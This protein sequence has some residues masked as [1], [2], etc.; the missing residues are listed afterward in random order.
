MNKI[1]LISLICVAAAAVVVGA[2]ALSGV[3][4][5]ISLANQG[6]NDNPDGKTVESLPNS[7]QT[8]VPTK[9]VDESPIVVITPTVQQ[10][11]QEPLPQSTP[12]Q[13]AAPIATITALQQEGINML[14]GTW[15]G[16]KS[17]MLGFVSGEVTVVFNKDM[18]GNSYGTINAPSFGYENVPLNSDL[19]YEYIGNNNFVGT[20]GN[21]ENSFTSDGTK[22]TITINPSAI[23]SSYPN[24]DI[25]IDLYKV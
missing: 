24:M 23:D 2:V 22:T 1:I 8:P 3:G 17:I 25:P 12:I 21:Q 13:T 4:I 16:T 5:S 9:H 6:T 10:T 18:T 11:I 15:H 19:T 7:V 20:L 14:S